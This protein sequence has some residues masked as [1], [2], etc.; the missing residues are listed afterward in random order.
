M[1]GT[2]SARP[3]FH[4]DAPCCSSSK[5]EAEGWPREEETAMQPPHACSAS[6]HCARTR[7]KTRAQHC[8][9]TTCGQRH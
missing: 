1:L 9:H 2:L 7:A 6:R 3:R 8:K 5:E 4:R